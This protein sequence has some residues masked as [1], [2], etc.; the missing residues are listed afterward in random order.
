[1]N[2]NK[3]KNISELSKIDKAEDIAQQAHLRQY[4]KI[5]KQPYIIHPKRVQLLAKSLNY[6]LDEQIVALLHDVIEDAKNPKYYYDLINSKFDKNILNALILLSHDKNV[7]YEKYLR[8]L[9]DSDSKSAKLAFRVKMLDIFDN[10]ND[11]PSE[12]QVKK[13]RNAILNLKDSKNFSEVPDKI[14]KLLNINIEKN[15][16]EQENADSKPKNKKDN[17]SDDDTSDN[18]EK[19]TNV[20]NKEFDDFNN[21][22]DSSEFNKKDGSNSK[23]SEDEKENTSIFKYNNKL[24]TSKIIYKQKINEPEPGFDFSSN[25][26]VYDKYY[27]SKSKNGSILIAIPNSLQNEDKY[28]VDFV[29]KFILSKIFNVI[30]SAFKLKKNVVLLGNYGIPF[31]KGKYLNSVSGYIAKILRNKYNGNIKFDSWNYG[32]YTSFVSNSEIWKEV[33]SRTGANRNEIKAALYLFLLSTGR[34]NIKSTQKLKTEEVLKILNRWGISDVNVQIPKIKDRIDRIIFPDD[35]GNAETFPSYIIKTYLQLLRVYMLK[36]VI[37]Y[38][39]NNYVV[40]VLSDTKTAWVLNDTFKEL[41]NIK[42]NKKE[43]TIVDNKKKVDVKK[44]KIR[45]KTGKER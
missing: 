44:D 27:V 11:Y 45:E 33:Q 22:A 16:T 17:E 41:H 42:N 12:N 43:K 20:S 36:K 10:L 40:I 14:L 32:D 9:I 6:G 19:K 7:P 31:I 26:D 2:K 39:K 34:E 28:K 23:D 21:D 1:M 8:K 35:Y 38:E 5:S 24:K 4:R 29:N 13:Y 30:D 25:A 37:K 18:S 3:I 15:I